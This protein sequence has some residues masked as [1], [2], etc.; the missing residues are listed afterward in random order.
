MEVMNYW[1]VIKKN[2]NFN[3]K[4][5]ST[6]NYCK[7]LFKLY[8]AKYG[9]AGWLSNMASSPEL[10]YLLLT[11]DKKL[12]DLLSY[13]RKLNFKENYFFNSADKLKKLIISDY[14][15]YFSEQMS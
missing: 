7:V 10:S 11:T 15:F 8:P 2:N 12:L 13:N 14:K 5:H 1:E 9:T 6:L 3:E 4:R